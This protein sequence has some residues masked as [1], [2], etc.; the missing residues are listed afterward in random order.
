MLKDQIE[1]QFCVA[2]KLSFQLYIWT[3][4]LK[5][6]CSK[7]ASTF[8]RFRKLLM[9]YILFNFSPIIIIKPYPVL[10]IVTPDH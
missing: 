10:S 7:F 9:F 4:G 2:K 8:S 5:G 3:L 6:N 1:S